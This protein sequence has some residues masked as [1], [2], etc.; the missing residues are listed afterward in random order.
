MQ[1]G[2]SFAAS[3]SSRVGIS[4]RPPPNAGKA[5]TFARGREVAALLLW[6]AALFHLLALASYAGEPRDAVSS[7]NIPSGPSPLAGP[8]WVGPVGASCARAMVNAVGVIAW[9]V[10]LEFAL[11]GIPYVTGRRTLITPGRLATDFLVVVIAAAMVQVGW[12]GKLAFGLHGASGVLG[13]LFGEIA[14]SLFSTIGSFL[15]GFACLGLLLI[16]RASFSFIALMNAIARFGAKGARGTAEG[17]RSVA[18]AWR[19]AREI[20]RGV[21]EEERILR[22]PHID[23]PKMSG[24]AVFAVSPSPAAPDI[25][26]RGCLRE[27]GRRRRRLSPKRRPR[28]KRDPIADAELARTEPARTE[29][30][31]KGAWATKTLGYPSATANAA[32]A[33]LRD[34]PLLGPASA[35][36]S[37]DVPSIVFTNTDADADEDLVS[38][39]PKRRSRAPKAVASSAVDRSR[40]RAPTS[41]RSSSSRWPWCP[42]SM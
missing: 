21:R 17:A 37:A 7:E 12:P 23:E 18:D 24:D 5:G 31:R 30:A 22:L 9:W 26:P 20:E 38:A 13:E 2:E 4:P 39:P 29:L 36:D 19:T 40:R 11:L 16:A 15:V 35:N 8:D 41:P 32:A 42:P 1:G 28:K 25:D 33:P 3:L 6:T 27:R 10:P 34:L 14:R